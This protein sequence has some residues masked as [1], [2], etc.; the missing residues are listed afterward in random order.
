MLL[1]RR[2]LA[3]S[4]DGHAG[5]GAVVC[6]RD[7]LAGVRLPLPASDTAVELLDWPTPL[8]LR[9]RRERIR[10]WRM[11]APPAARASA[12][13]VAASPGPWPICCSSPLRFAA[14]PSAF[15]VLSCRIDPESPPERFVFSGATC[16]DDAQQ[17]DRRLHV[18]GELAGRLHR[19]A[20]VVARRRSTD[21]GRADDCSIDCVVWFA[22][23]ATPM[24][25][26]VF[27]WV[28]SPL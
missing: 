27:A 2:R 4:L 19:D 16:T 21:H 6:L 18:A 10:A 11:P 9:L 12:C 3:S 1:V 5:R 25:V 24:A 17:T 28:T 13:R 22:L 7:R 26:D 8:G 15:D 20:V 23:S 14:T